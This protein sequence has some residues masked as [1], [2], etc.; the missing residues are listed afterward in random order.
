MTLLNFGNYILKPCT[1]ILIVLPEI[2]TKLGKKYESGCS[3]CIS[4]KSQHI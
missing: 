2:S 4:I 3:K 1:V